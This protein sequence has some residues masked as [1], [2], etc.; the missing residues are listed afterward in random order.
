MRVYEGSKGVHL[1]FVAPRD[2]NAR[3][4]SNPVSNS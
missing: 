3:C 4:S 1:M 2:G